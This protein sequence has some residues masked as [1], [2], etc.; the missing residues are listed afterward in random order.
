MMDRYNLLGE[1]VEPEASFWSRRRYLSAVTIEDVL[2]RFDPDPYDPGEEAR[3]LPFLAE[4]RDNARDPNYFRNGGHGLK[5]LSP[6]LRDRPFTQQPP[7]GA[8]VSRR[9]GFDPLIDNGLELATLFEAE[10]P[11]LWHRHV[12]NVLLEQPRPDPNGGEPRPWREALSPPRQ[13]LYWHLLDV[14]IDSALAAVWHF[15]WLAT[16]EPDVAQRDRIRY[17]RRPA[18][19][20]LNRIVYDFK[21]EHDK[22]GN[23]FR[24]TPKRSRPCRHDPSVPACPPPPANPIPT[25][26]TPRHP[27]YGSGHSTYSQAASAVMKHVFADAPFPSLFRDGWQPLADNIGEAR[28]WG[29]V[30]W[31]RDH[32]FGQRLGQAVA[33]CLIEQL[34]T[35]RVPTPNRVECCPPMIDELEAREKMFQ[36][37]AQPGTGDKEQFRISPDSAQG[38]Q[39]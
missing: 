11:G 15:K 16:G 17:R 35:S 36:G 28:F 34:K 21:V 29:G 14:A 1:Q 7:V 23:I 4:L 12:L 39:G 5:P 2:R 6:Y 19:A 8:V 37:P 26:G 13:A 38:A 32:E 3:D 27:A 20:G 10:T 30:H 22:T 25:P 33:D 18:E 31:R 9:P 24:T